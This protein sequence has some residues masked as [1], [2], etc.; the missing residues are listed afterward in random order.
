MGWTLE[1][2]D[3]LSIADVHEGITQLQTA[4]MARAHNQRRAQMQADARKPLGR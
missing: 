4:D 3:G 1:Y 2:I